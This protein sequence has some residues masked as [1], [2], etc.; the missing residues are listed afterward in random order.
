MSN[1]IV[2][3]FAFG[4]IRTRIVEM[5]RKGTSV[6]AG[7]LRATNRWSELVPFRVYPFARLRSTSDHAKRMIRDARLTVPAIVITPRQTAGRG[8]GTNRWYSPP[9]SLAA[10][11]V[12]RS[13]ASCSPV[14]LSLLWALA[15][16]RALQE[17][18]GKSPQ[19]K[20]PNDVMWRGKKLCG[21]LC[22]RFCGVDVVG[23]GINL[24]R[25]S[26]GAP[27]QIRVKTASLA[28]LTSRPVDRFDVLSCVVRQVRGMLMGSRTR[29]VEELLRA[30]DAQHMLFGRR[31]RVHSVEDD[32]EIAAGLCKGI[33]HHGRLIVE[34]KLGRSLIATGRVVF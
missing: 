8:R 25:L 10:T 18:T 4:R 11:F 33:D 30:F 15:I 26:V 1:P 21:I 13:R 19:L 27:Q 23:V 14:Q 5:A 28:D 29:P 16:R 6:R 24:E 20:W 2:A 17:L 32:R 34:T 31:V 22:E 7:T 3:D 12:V 9:G